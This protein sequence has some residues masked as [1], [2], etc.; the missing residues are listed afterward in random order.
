MLKAPGP[1][2]DPNAGKFSPAKAFRA[3]PR[4]PGSPE[5]S[6]GYDPFPA[7]PGEV[8]R[9]IKSTTTAMDGLKGASAQASHEVDKLGPQAVQASNQAVGAFH[10]AQGA[11]DAIHDKRIQIIVDTGSLISRMQAINNMVLHD[12]TFTITQINRVVELNVGPGGGA[13]HLPTTLG[14]GGK[15]SA[16]GGWV[17]GPGTGTSDSVPMRLSNG[18]F[19]VGA[20]MA[21]QNANMLQAMNSGR[22]ANSGAPV[23]VTVVGHVDEDGY[24]TGTAQDVY[25]A[26]QDFD[27]AHG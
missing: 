19:V 15:T 6:A 13:H 5:E 17:S 2:A 10:R 21:R 7:V 3:P 8:T 16:A 9:S 14:G 22:S 20:A 1:L 23:H 18:E 12:K 26:N 4:A 24:I 25:A 27:R 11:L